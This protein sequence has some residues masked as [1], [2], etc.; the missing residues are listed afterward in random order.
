MLEPCTW[1]WFI[2]FVKKYEVLRFFFSRGLGEMLSINVKQTVMSAGGN[3]KPSL[4][5]EGQNEGVKQFFTL[6]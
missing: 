3:S 2:V 4:G 6:P 1:K 5:F